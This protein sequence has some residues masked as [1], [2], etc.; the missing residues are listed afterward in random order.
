MAAA[1][2]TNE[3][4]CRSIGG[5]SRALGR[6]GPLPILSLPQ[7]MGHRSLLTFLYKCAHEFIPSP[8]PPGRLS[9]ESKADDRPA[10]FG[11]LQAGY[12]S[13]SGRFRVRPTLIRHVES[14]HEIS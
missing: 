12:A 13:D 7:D 2:N 9:I 14:R 5:T 4:D 6:D 8:S 1:M 3:K 10:T 11:S